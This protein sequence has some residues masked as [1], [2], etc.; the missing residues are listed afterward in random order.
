M[1]LPE[2]MVADVLTTRE[3][4]K[5]SSLD[6]ESDE[7][8]P[9]GADIEKI[10]DDK[11]TVFQ[12]PVEDKIVLETAVNKLKIIEQK[13]IQDFYFTG[14]TQ[15]EIAKKLGISCNYVSHILRNGTKKLRRILSTDELMEVQIQLQLASRSADA[16]VASTNAVVVDA[17][18]GLYNASYMEARLEEEISRAARSSEE[19]AFAAIMITGLAE[20]GKRCGTMREED[21]IC[22]VA[23]LIKNN[24]RRCDI[25][26]RMSDSSFAFILPH[27]GAQASVVCDRV[28][29]AVDEFLTDLSAGKPLVRFASTTAYASCPKDSEVAADMI[30]MATLIGTDSQMEAA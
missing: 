28:Q 18:T 22:G 2:E 4:F 13:V 12:L 15:T 29:A 26:G 17:L 11:Y 19:V 8:S 20:N 3:I 16:L 5:V 21:A 24:V 23:Q 6:A 30:A 10:T 27:T 7:S 9:F 1:H 14:L 25:V